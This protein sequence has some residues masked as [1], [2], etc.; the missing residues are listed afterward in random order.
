M[1]HLIYNLGVGGTEKMLL[2]TLPRLSD[3]RHLV[4]VINS[5]S[6]L[7]SGELE[8]KGITVVRLK[9]AKIFH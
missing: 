8:A 2:N 6:P 1:I 5:V 4:C 7:I 9:G 3:F